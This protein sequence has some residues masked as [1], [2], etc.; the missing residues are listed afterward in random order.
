[1]AV[2]EEVE[3]TTAGRGPVVPTGAPPPAVAAFLDAAHAVAG[4]ADE[5][6]HRRAARGGPRPPARARGVAC[7]SSGAEPP[8]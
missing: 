6:D 5:H 3:A 1:M 7:A 4:R 8:R 2:R